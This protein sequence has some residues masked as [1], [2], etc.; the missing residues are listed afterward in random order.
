MAATEPR[1]V[2]YARRL[3]DGHEWQAD[4]YAPSGM[5]HCPAVIVLPGETSTRETPAFRDMGAALAER[6]IVAIVADHWPAPGAQMMREGGAGFR[7][8]VENVSC[9]VRSAGELAGVE[10]ERVAIYGQSAGGVDGLFVALEGEAAPDAWGGYQD[11]AI[12]QQVECATD[13][14]AFRLDGFVGLNGGYEA[15][16]AMRSLNEEL[17]QFM[18]PFSRVEQSARTL[19]FI[20]GTGDETIPAPIQG[21][22]RELFSTLKQTG[23]D[24]AVREVDDVHIPQTGSAGWVASLDAIT[25]LLGGSR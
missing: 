6:G 10:A 14:G 15:P 11:G 25:E 24:V 23:H 9:L 18:S 16:Y 17:G 22:H 19:R 20:V 4:I 13:G 21:R 1:T 5:G 2:T 3:R 12:G 7:E 8:A